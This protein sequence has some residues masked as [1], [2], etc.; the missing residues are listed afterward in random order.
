M[1]ER[2]Q[3]ELQ[4]IGNA[5][6]RALHLKRDSEHADRWQTLWGTKTGAGLYRTIRQMM[7]HAEETTMSARQVA[8]EIERP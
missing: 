3:E 4:V 8:K 5:L 2:T 6:A 1:K 7:R